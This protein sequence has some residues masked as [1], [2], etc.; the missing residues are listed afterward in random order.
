VVANP[1]IALEAVMTV[2][3]ELQVLAGPEAIIF[4]AELTNRITILARGAYRGADEPD[5]ETLR[6]TNETL[7]AISA[8]LIGL[9]RGTGRFEDERF[10]Q[11]IRERANSAFSS[12]LEWAIAD[13]LRSVDAKRK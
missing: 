7:H 8:K 12:G 6:A 9:A 3:Q 4:L 5:L 13:A 1:L 10:L 11:S 2:E